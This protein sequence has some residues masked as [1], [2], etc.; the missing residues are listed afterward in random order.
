MGNF[1]LGRQLQPGDKVGTWN[2][3]MG[4]AD[5]TVKKEVGQGFPN[6]HEARKG[7][8]AT[9]EAGVVALDNNGKIRA[10]TVDDGAYVDD[11]DIGDK[12]AG[13]A[14]GTLD[15]LNQ[16][17]ESLV[18]T[19]EIL[20]PLGKDNGKVVHA[21]SSL[22]SLKDKAALRTPNQ[23]AQAD[24][25]TRLRKMGYTVMIDNNPSKAEFQQ[26]LY[27]PRTAGIMWLGHGGGGGVVDYNHQWINPR[28][29]DPKRVSPNMKMML[30]QS[31]QV[32]KAQT[33]WEKLLPGAQVQAWDRN[34][35]NGELIAYNMRDSKLEKLI[36]DTL[37]GSFAQ[38]VYTPPPGGLLGAMGGLAAGLGLGLGAAGTPPKTKP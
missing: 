15:F 27:D 20:P 14:V 4:K 1:A 6:V 34:V 37:G 21:M 35:M 11:L 31:C 3:T 23:L 38:E 36:E 32:G 16:E 25:I 24:D 19:Q 22:S 9:G 13:K 7:I 12:I 5:L 28:D 10:Y 33:Q 30:F 26:A 8:A 18:T 2:S 29:I 17:G